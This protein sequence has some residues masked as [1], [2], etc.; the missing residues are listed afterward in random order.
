MCNR[1]KL[2]EA[3][4]KVKEPNPYMKKKGLVYEVPVVSVTT[5]TLGKL[6]GHRR[7]D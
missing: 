1:G 4:L 7:N 3:L 6:G 5:Y 2:R